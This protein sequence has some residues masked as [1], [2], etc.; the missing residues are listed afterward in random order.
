MNY[1]IFSLDCDRILLIELIEPA[2]F[3]KHVFDQSAAPICHFAQPVGQAP[4]HLILP[5]VGFLAVDRLVGHVP[6]VVR[7]ELLHPL[8]LDLVYQVFQ[9][10]LKS[11][12]QA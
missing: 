12:R 2:F 9:Y 7:D 4:L 8:P 6:D 1:F 10:L 5:A 3:L 11:L